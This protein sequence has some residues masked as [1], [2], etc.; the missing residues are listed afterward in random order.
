MTITE[1]Q[2]TAQLAAD[3]AVSA[4][5]A[6]QYM[7]EAEQG[8]QDTSA[9]A[10]Q[11]QDAAGSALLSKQSAATSE[12]NSLQYATEAGVA[13]DEAVTAASNASEYAQNKFTF[14]KTASDP[15]GT[16]AGLA[17]TTDGQSFW[18]A[19]GPD[20]L[21]AAWQYQNKAGVAVLQ[22]KQ[23]GTAAITGTIREFP[24]LAAAQADADAGNIPVGSN[25]YYRDSDYKYLAIEVINNSGILSATGRVM[26]S[27][28]YIDDLA[29]RGLIS[30][31]LD[32]GLDIVD[33]EYDPVS[34]R[35]SKFTMRDGR[36]FIPL[37]QLSENS[38]T[39]NNIQNGSVSSEKLS[40]D[41]QSILSQE[42]DPDTGFSEI[43]YDP[44]T[45]RMCSYTTT[46]GQVF[47]PLLQVPE[48]SVGNS[49][50]S[51]EVQQVIPLDLDPDT[52]YVSV[53]YDPVTKR[54][55]SY[56][57]TDGDVFISRLLLGD[58]IVRFSTLTE[59]VQN[60]IIAHPQDVVDARPDATRS[61]LSE[62]AV[63]TNARDGSAWSPLP[64]HVC[65][66]AFGINGTG[67]AIEYR[68]ASGLLF[69]GKAR[70]GVF[71]PGAVPSLTK[72]GRFLTTAVTT[73]TGTFAV[74]DYYSYEAYNTN[75]NLSETL[76]GTWG[77]QSLYCG[78][79]LVWNGTEFVIQ[80]GPGTGVIKIADSWYEVTAAGTFNGMALQAGDKLLYTGLQTA[81]G[82]SMTPRWVLLSSASDALVYAGEFAPAS[83]YPA[84][85]L[86]NSVYQAS[87][88]G[89]IS[90]NSF[91]AGD[92]AL[93]DGSAWI[94]I[95][96]QASVTVAAGS[97]ISLRCS[98]NSDEWE[99]RRSDKSYGPVGVRLKA[100]VM[101]TIRK[102]LGS[103]L[104]L[105]GDSLFGSG[106]SGN[107]I[108]SEVSVP[109]EVRSYGGS[110]SDQVLGMLKQEILVNGDN[111]AGQVICFWHGQNNQPTIDLNAAQI[112]QDSIEMAALVGAR[113]ARYIFLT[114]MGQRTETWNGSRIVVQQH[115]DQFAKTGVLYELCEWYRRMFP[116]RWFNVYQNM[117]AAA[118]DAIDPTFPGMTEKQVAST[119]GVL[120]WS[121]FNGGSFTGF[122]T[123]DLVYKGTWSDTVLPTGGSSMDYYIR[124]GGGTVGNI[125]YNN[126][127]V[128][129]EKSIDRTHLSN[130]GGLALANGGAGFSTISSS[131][132][133]AGMLNNNF[134]F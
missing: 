48:N 14:Y 89:T 113:D 105:I 87:A 23:P 67:T 72:K 16:I 52:G 86:R 59:D 2:K 115:E 64:S 71:T 85:P 133:L 9:A 49:Q 88:A 81:G 74:G 82:A 47:I 20:A 112:R 132:G 46:D 110:T 54:M 18:V 108:L 91:S 38:V 130:S 103:K 4:A 62:I 69:T 39:G 106:N 63:R 124:I 68:Q 129:S 33:V 27:K 41:V 30:T 65:K 84:S 93:W 5:E 15:D 126:G 36:V 61:T 83:G 131:E 21:S 40:L 90:G 100:Q 25:A 117:L 45:R 53:D 95:A 99:I 8:Y 22:A 123:N 78:D 127:G 31:E 37:L 26:I 24:S 118:T 94:R 92:Y 13:R 32:D 114:I 121:F 19:Q 66:A 34:M 51:T 128:W 35:M 104:L 17:A 12:E 73:P 97:S 6:K 76:P 109:G 80:R 96:G 1:T 102:S 11:A 125:I 57:T 28:G 50:L 42:L 7:L 29:S 10:Q 55:S 134:F 58:D 79:N 43:N 3:A 60:K 70:A 44:V 98:Q 120:P 77:S 101:T 122:T 75:G 119:Y 107:Q 111:Y 116:G 56:V